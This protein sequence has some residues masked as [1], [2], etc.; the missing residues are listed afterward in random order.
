MKGPR[1]LTLINTPPLLVRFIIKFDKV[2]VTVETSRQKG[3]LEIPDRIVRRLHNWL[4]WYLA[5]K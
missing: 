4:G 1:Q 5:K 3:G 2:K